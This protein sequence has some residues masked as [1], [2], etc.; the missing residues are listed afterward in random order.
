MMGR[1][2]AGGLGHA[3]RQT[4]PGRQGR[5]AL[6]GPLAVAAI[7][8]FAIEVPMLQRWSI[9]SQVNAVSRATV[10]ST[11]DDGSQPAFL[12]RDPV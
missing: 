3:S 1:G 2:L 8:R 4:P 6:H 10:R 9:D 7:D 12:S 5:R 11:E